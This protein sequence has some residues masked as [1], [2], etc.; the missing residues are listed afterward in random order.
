MNDQT[1][2]PVIQGGSPHNVPEFFNLERVFAQKQLGQV[3]F[4]HEAA[5]GPAEPDTLYALSVVISTAS[6]PRSWA[7][8]VS[9][10]ALYLGWIDIGFATS[11]PP[12]DHDPGAGS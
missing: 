10:W 3:P 9:R 11:A 4:D 8:N 6:G 2:A 5:T 12:V 7:M 1:L